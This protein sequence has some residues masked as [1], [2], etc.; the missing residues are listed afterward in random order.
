MLQRPAQDIVTNPL[1]MFSRPRQSAVNTAP[2]KRNSFSSDFDRDFADIDP[3]QAQFMLDSDD[4]DESSFRTPDES[5]QPIATAG[6]PHIEDRDAGAPQLASPIN[7]VESHSTVSDTHA[8]QPAPVENEIRGSLQSAWMPPTESTSSPVGVARQGIARKPLPASLVSTYNRQPEMSEAPQEVPLE[9]PAN[10]AQPSAQGNRNQSDLEENESKEKTKK[11]FSSFFDKKDR[12]SAAVSPKKNRRSTVSSTKSSDN[13]TGDSEK[14]L[15]KPDERSAGYTAV[16]NDGPTDH[17][18]DDDIFPQNPAVRPPTRSNSMESVPQLHSPVDSKGK[19]KAPMP[20]PLHIPTGNIYHRCACCG[21][22]KRPP[23]YTNELSPV[24]ENE[25]IR[26]NFSI[27]MERDR[28]HQINKAADAHAARSRRHTPIIPMEVHDDDDKQSVRTVQASIEAYEGPPQAHEGRPQLPSKESS[29]S[30][31]VVRFSSLHNKLDKFDNVG[32]SGSTSNEVVARSEPVV[33]RPQ[34]SRSASSEYSVPDSVG[35]QEPKHATS[36]VLDFQQIN[37]ND[38]EDMIKPV[39]RRVTQDFITVVRPTSALWGREGQETPTASQEASH[40]ASPAEM[41]AVAPSPSTEV[42]QPDGEAAPLPEDPKLSKAEQ[43]QA[44]A[45]EKLEQKSAAKIK[46]EMKQLEEQ[47]RKENRMKMKEQEKQKQKML[48][49]QKE[50]QAK[51]NQKML[52]QQKED[53]EKQKQLQK[54]EQAREKVEKRASMVSTNS[55]EKATPRAPSR[56]LDVA[57]PQS[58]LV[59]PTSRETTK[60][61]PAK[62]RPL[63]TM[64]SSSPARPTS[65]YQSV[66]LPATADDN[67]NTL[68]T[69]SS[70]SPQYTPDGN[71][72][73]HAPKLSL[74]LGNGNFS[75]FGTFDTERRPPL[76]TP[77]FGPHFSKSNATLRDFMFSL[78]NG[79]SG[80]EGEKAVETGIGPQGREQVRAA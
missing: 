37:E 79:Q 10:M 7:A 57:R 6:P 21:R 69:A 33:E 20:A 68:T 18:N 72:K 56:F 41:K 75:D 14:P 70:R 44:L 58:M 63:S 17:Q 51:E 47:H 76:P 11:R 43:K 73:N 28:L 32:E 22:L 78:Q 54:E 38:D 2:D 62:Q 39:Q 1:S 25:N 29:Q 80:T 48:K 40:Y 61:L 52:K 12:P 66:T 65:A 16:D 42:T 26:H 60:E 24:L 35:R 67:A 13:T 46:A 5:H 36:G 77:N 74:G 59:A 9:Q 55:S 8:S 71:P 50:E 45:R 27:E 53:Q 4:T 3:H 15:P 19:A 64:P 30:S 34:P 31:K 23:T 49:Q